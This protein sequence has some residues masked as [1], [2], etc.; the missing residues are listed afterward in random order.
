[1]IV[2][3]ACGVFVAA[4]V[5]M[6]PMR[7]CRST[8][9][10]AG[11]PASAARTQVATAAP[12]GALD[13]T[14]TVRFD[15]NV[16]GG[17]PGASRRSR[18]RSRSASAR[19]S[20]STTS[21]PT[22][23][24]ARRSGRRPTTS[25]RPRPAA[26]FQKIECFCFTEQRLAGR[27]AR[28]AGRVLR[29]SGARQGSRAATTSNTITLSYTFYRAARAGAGRWRQ[30][31]DEAGDE[32]NVGRSRA[33]SETRRRWPTRTPST[34]TTTWS[35]RARGRSSA[36]SRPSCSRSALITW[37]HKMFAGGAAGCSP[38]ARSACSTPWSAGGA[39]SSRKPSTRA[40]TP[41]WCRS[42]TA[43]A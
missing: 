39:T 28:D 32:L 31:A 25:R 16:A 7:R 21:R 11:P 3:A 19:S 30:R 2:A 8:T 20:P 24:R 6:S 4:M 23:R 9:G 43:T 37:M 12:H 26:Y 5:G 33:E 42:R 15:A 14:I 38:P 34:T 27:E 17:L 36:R 35:I 41:A 13:R 18:T 29:R 10:S 40:T 1:M 22:S